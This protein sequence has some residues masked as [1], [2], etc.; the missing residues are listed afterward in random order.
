ML[1]FTHLIVEVSRR[2]CLI[3]DTARALHRVDRDTC[4]DRIADTRVRGALS[5]QGQL[6]QTLDTRV[7]AVS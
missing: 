6:S 3:V 4:T 2:F 5:T 7:S 1:L